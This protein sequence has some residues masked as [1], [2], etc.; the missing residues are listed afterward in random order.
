MNSYQSMGVPPS[1]SS[2]AQFYHQAAA[3]A[4]SAANAGVA[5]MDSLG[6]CTQASSGTVASS[7]ASAAAAAGAAGL[8]DLPRYPWMALT[9]GNNCVFCFLAFRLFGMVIDGYTFVLYG[10]VDAVR[11]ERE[12]EYHL[13]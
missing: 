12:K 11:G 8:P 3:S 1:A 7:V 4:V 10:L 9:G 2:F 5:G 6:N 13:L